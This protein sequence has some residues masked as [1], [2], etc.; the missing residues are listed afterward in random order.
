MSARTTSPHATRPVFNDRYHSARWSAVARAYR[1][2]PRGACTI[3]ALR[4]RFV[5]SE[6]TLWPCADRIT[7][8]G[9]SESRGSR[10]VVGDVAISTG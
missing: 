5:S 9:C 2:S 8:P 4:L 10:R 7:V 3:V 6:T 1:M